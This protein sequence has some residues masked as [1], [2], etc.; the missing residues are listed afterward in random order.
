MASCA[1]VDPPPLPFEIF[2]SVIDV[3]ISRAE[4][5]ADPISMR[6]YLSL[7]SSTKSRLSA[8]V[9]ELYT[10]PQHTVDEGM[11]RFRMLRLASQISSKTRSMVHQKFHRIT[12]WDPYAQRTAFL[13][14]YP[15]ID[16]FA[17]IFC[18]MPEDCSRLRQALQQPTPEDSTLVQCIVSIHGMPR[19]FLQEEYATDIQTVL[20]LPN[21]REITLDSDVVFVSSH[22]QVSRDHPHP[23]DELIPIDSSIFPTLGKWEETHGEALDAFC[24]QAQERGVAVFVGFGGSASRKKVELFPTKD[25]V[26]VKLVG[27]VC[28]CNGFQ[29]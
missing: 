21:L 7:N 22:H 27:Y 13:W 28:T 12:I 6:F 23:S 17:P 18:T 1:D 10:G 19:E 24:R 8:Q 14:V 29:Q 4:Y 5:S 9:S 20:S 16:R 26:R 25:G 11:W 3:L 2:L 15:K